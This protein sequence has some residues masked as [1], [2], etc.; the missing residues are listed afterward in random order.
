MA[1]GHEVE[2]LVDKLQTI[3]E[4]RANTTAVILLAVVLAVGTV[5]NSGIDLDLKLQLGGVHGGQ[6]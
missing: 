6:K 4:K 3:Y 1:K 2:K 5:A